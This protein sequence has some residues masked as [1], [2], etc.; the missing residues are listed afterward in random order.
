MTKEIHMNTGDDKVR[1]QTLA[2]ARSYMMLLKDRRFDEWIELWA[3]DGTC[4][5]PYAPEDRR[6]LQGKKPIY[7]YMTAYPEVM[8]IDSV[9][10]MR[11]HPMLNP[12]IAV[13]ELAIT[14]RALKTGRP[15]N[16]RYVIF[17]EAQRGKIWRYREYWNSS[18]STEAFGGVDPMQ[19]KTDGARAT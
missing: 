5:F 13:V 17:I 19:S 11:V 3:D 8:A 18:I 12:E 16:Q 10:D 7:D 1:D 15:Y 6:L 4:E 14:G 2:I 9:A